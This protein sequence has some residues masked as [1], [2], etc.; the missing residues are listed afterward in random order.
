MERERSLVIGASGQIGIELLLA[1]KQRDGAQNVVGAD[2]RPPEHPDLSDL[3]FI[4]LNV[5]NAQAIEK[6]LT[7]HHIDTVYN[8]AAMLSATAEQHPEKA[9]DLNMNGLFNLLEPARRGMIKKV[10]WPS[11]IAVFGPSTPKV[12]TPQS[13][14]CEP[15][16]VYGISKLA[17]EQWCAY[18]HAKYGVDVRSIRY[19]GLIGHRS[20]PGGG[21][22]DYAVH[23][24]HEALKHSS[25]TSFLS[26]STRLPMMYIEDAIKATLQLMAAPSEA[27]GIRS[28]YNLS[29]IDFT[30]EELAASIRRNIPDFTISYA[31]DFRQH[32]ADG[33]P[34]S[35]DDT[36]A[37]TDWGWK[38]SYSLDRMVD[39]MLDALQKK[40]R[41]RET[42]N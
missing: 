13:T 38:S 3:P 22:T 36:A 39:T 1:L 30:P 24:F 32:I 27:I 33:W 34:S 40:N 4:H 10:F 35:I 23:I 31:P 9:W 5:L 8:L 15:N 19:P 28:S 2:I 42:M 20:A 7:D 26:E 14:V 41:L 37:Q 16:T 29:G 11:S 25:Y 21:T 17:G 6:T 12:K 18:Y